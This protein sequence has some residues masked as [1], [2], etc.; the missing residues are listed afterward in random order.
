MRIEPGKCP[1]PPA[2]R[3]AAAS[4]TN[5]PFYARAEE[6]INSDDEL[7]GSIAVDLATQAAREHAFMQQLTQRGF[8]LKRMADDGNCLFRS[9]A[10]RVY[11]DAE[12]C[13]T[14]HDFFAMAAA[15]AGPQ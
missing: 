11:G 13:D 6:D 12:V 3:H 7:G 1:P 10:D 15:A 9:I 2:R 8:E 5:A 4:S 14:A